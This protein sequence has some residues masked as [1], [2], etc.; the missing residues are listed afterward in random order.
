VTDFF[1][2]FAAMGPELATKIEVQQGIN[3]AKA[4]SKTSSLKHYIWSTLPNASRISGGKFVI[5]YFDGKNQ[6]DDWI[7]KDLVLYPKTTFL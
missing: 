6:I 7:K 4:A 1:E 5:P 2:P 3:L